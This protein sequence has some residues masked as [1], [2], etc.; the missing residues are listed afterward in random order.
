MV[1][2]RVMT[3]QIG[4][5]KS[6]TRF[7]LDSI[8]NVS[9]RGLTLASKF[10]LLVYLARVLPP[11]QLGVY[12]LFTVTIIYA[13][14]LL[15]LDFYTYAQREMLSLPRAE[16]G[17]LIRNQ[18]M[19]YAVVYLVVLP[20]LLLVFVVGWLPWQMIGWFYILLT[21]EHLS[22]ELGRL[23]VAC[24]KILLVNV[25]LFFRG[26]AW[27]FAVVAIFNAN[28]E[29]HCLTVIWAGW[30]VGVLISIVIAIIGVRTSIGPMPENALTDWRWVRRGLKVA[31][32]FLLGTLALRGLFT[33]DRY[34]LDLYVGKSA[35]GV[36]S[37]F[38]SIANA[39]LA[40]ADA[41]VISRLYPRIVA[42]Y[43]TGRYVEYKMQLKK[44]T[45]GIIV[46]LVSFSICLFI[47]IDPVLLYIGRQVYIEQTLTLWVLLAAMGTFCLGMI[48]HYVL[49][50][51]HCDR[52]I[53]VASILSLVVFLGAAICLTPNSGATG[54]ATSV[55]IGVGSLGLI[56]MVFIMKVERSAKITSHNS[57]N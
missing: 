46:L 25:A 3:E 5:L 38:M 39:L 35:V 1:T 50:A 45:F 23:L 31:A 24:G 44:L 21:L 40:F 6:A 8:V 41:G 42:A 20:L 14:Y 15:G 47:A 56:K 28:S 32:Q 43:R 54:M 22:Q 2:A 51:R 19:F 13:L 52:S 10:I 55:L 49:Y 7:A 29:L 34:F 27:I 57:S 18:F 16:W 4:T 12:G 53:A 33:F 37:F 26:G 11:E 48:P 30:S 17:G 36:Y 9:L